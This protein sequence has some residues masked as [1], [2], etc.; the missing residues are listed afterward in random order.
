M[1]ANK[2]I[3]TLEFMI[4]RV[5]KSKLIDKIVIATTIN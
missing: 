1:E 3:S 4:N 5:K 2:E